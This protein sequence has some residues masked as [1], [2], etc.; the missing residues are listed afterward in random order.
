MCRLLAVRNARPFSLGAELVPF[1]ALARQSR[2][3][4]GHGW[5]CAWQAAGR[6]CAYRT[7][8]PIWEDDLGRFGEATVL[9]A[10]A[11]S[12]FRNEGIAVEN[13][14]PF[15]EADAAFVFNGELRGVRIRETG[16]IGAEKLFR[17]LL[18]APPGGGNGA[19]AP[20]GP[21]VGPGGAERLRRAI[22]LVKQ[23]TR[24]L[25]A[26]NFVLASPSC[27]MAYSSFNEDPDYFTVHIQRNGARVRIAS[28]PFPPESA[29][30]GA[31]AAW[32]PLAPNR[33]EL[34]AW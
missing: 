30:P 21:A 29:V 11:R 19:A 27:F 9:V 25:R 4:Q 34:I 22:E 8:R 1:A 17:F 14:M 2:E 6:W 3:Y 5:G 31:R 12:A 26:M 20:G 23:R 10:H 33:L 24:Y 18:S 13:N 28:D 15:I 7:V 16:R 32:T